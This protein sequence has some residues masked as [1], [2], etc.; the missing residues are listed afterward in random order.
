MRSGRQACNFINETPPRLFKNTFFN[1]TFPVAAADSFRFPASSFIKKETWAKMF[2]FEFCEIFKNVFCQNTS[3]WLLLLFI[4]EFWEIFQIISFNR[5]LLGNYLFHLQVA[6]FQP[7][8][9]VN[10]YFTCA[11]QAFYTRRSSYLKTSMY[12]KYLKIILKK[13]ICNEVVRFQPAS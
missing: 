11:F 4:C 3:G 6:K 13:L 8:H 2:I 5:A 12:L 7:P 1:R 10:K 9:T